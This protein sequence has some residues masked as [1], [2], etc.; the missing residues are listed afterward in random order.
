MRVAGPARAKIF[1]VGP[2]EGWGVRGGG[3]AHQAAGLAGVVGSVRRNVE[4]IFGARQRA[5]DF[6]LHRHEAGRLPRLILVRSII[7]R[8]PEA[9]DTSDLRG[10]ALERPGERGGAPA[11]KHRAAV[12]GA[13]S[14]GK[15]NAVADRRD[16]HAGL[17]ATTAGS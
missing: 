1:A 14:R 10:F 17:A 13:A 9:N 12:G 8:I 3:I 5:G 4:K 11:I 7:V 15:Q 6:L 16:R 2:A